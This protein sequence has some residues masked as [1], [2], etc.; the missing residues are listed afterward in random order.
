MPIRFEEPA[1]FRV[2]P[3]VTTRKLDKQVGRNGGRSARA[4]TLLELLLVVAIISMLAGMALPHVRTMAKSNSMSAATRQL[5]DDIGYA[6]Q[7]ALANHTAVYMV[8]L[9]SN[10]LGGNSAVMNQPSPKLRGDVD[11]LLN[12][13]LRG[14]ALLTLRSAGDQPGQSYPRY[15][16]AWRKLPEGVYIPPMKFNSDMDFRTHPDT[17]FPARISGFGSME[18]PFPYVGGTNFLMPYIKFDPR[19]QCVHRVYGSPGYSV[20]DVGYFEDVASDGEFIPL[21]RGSVFLFTN[22]TPVSV[23]VVETPRGE[24]TNNYNIIA[25]DGFTGRAKLVRKEIK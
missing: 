2:I 7:A 12:A 19:G 13:Q 14:Y 6:R 21:T 10:L 25:I 9:S 1:Q 8:F 11:Q 18:F 4:F 5:L 3:V 20:R 17:N 23:D 16:T 15:L 22:S 24:S